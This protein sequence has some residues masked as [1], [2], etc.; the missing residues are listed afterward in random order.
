MEFG[1]GGRYAPSGDDFGERAKGTEEEGLRGRKL[2]A[3][4]RLPSTDPPR[5]I[6]PSSLSGSLPLRPRRSQVVLKSYQA[7]RHPLFD[8]AL[9]LSR[10]LA[11]SAVGLAGVD[12]WETPHD[13]SREPSREPR[14]D[15]SAFCEDEK[16]THGMQR[17]RWEDGVSI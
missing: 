4:P 17:K 14:F 9:V 11:P 5:P 7:G 8:W 2:L 16:A 3:W 13:A 6:A 10:S 1:V 15:F 12:Q